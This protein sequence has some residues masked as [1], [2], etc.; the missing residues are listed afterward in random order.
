MCGAS[1]FVRSLIF[2][3]GID[4]VSVVCVSGVR[5]SVW[6]C[7]TASYSVKNAHISGVHISILI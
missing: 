2:A 5:Y 3:V 7:Q 1:C 6:R 4:T